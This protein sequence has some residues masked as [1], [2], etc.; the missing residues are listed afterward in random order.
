[1]LAARM[2]MAAAGAG[3]GAV[4]EV[5]IKVWGAGGGGGAV[6]NDSLSREGANG[7]IIAGT[8]LIP[9][10]TALKVVVGAPGRGNPYGTGGYNPENTGTT[11]NSGGLGYSASSQGGGNGGRLFC[12]V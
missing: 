5:T 12:C 4:V 3:G 7:G 11:T 10:G 1:M 2:L 8:F 9:A 6:I